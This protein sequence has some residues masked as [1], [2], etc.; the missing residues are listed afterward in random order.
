M[1]IPVINRRFEVKKLLLNV[2]ELRVESFATSGARAGRGTVEG[3]AID[4]NDHEYMIG[5]SDF[6]CTLVRCTGIECKDSFGCG[7]QGCMTQGGS[8]C[9]GDCTNYQCLSHDGTCNEWACGSGTC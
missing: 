5:D 9:A 2:E 7:S 4:T 8:S 3:R 6:G 1:L